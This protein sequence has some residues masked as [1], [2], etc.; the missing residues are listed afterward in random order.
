MDNIIKSLVRKTLATLTYIIYFTTN[1]IDETVKRLNNL[2]LEEFV[3]VIIQ[4]DVSEIF[5][6][7]YNEYKKDELN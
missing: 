3:W 7:L 5:T 2:E 6:H 4:D 1:S